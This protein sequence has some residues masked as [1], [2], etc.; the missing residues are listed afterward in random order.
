[1]YINS[2]SDFRKAMRHG[3]YA[4]PGGYPVYFITDDRA[5]ISFEGAK[6]ARRDLLE[7]IRDRDSRGYRVIAMDVNWEDSTLI[8]DITNE[9]I[10]SAYG[11]D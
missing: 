4:W 8:C 11:E 2:I 7:S 6:M 3:P 10:E 9:R 5:A 1:M